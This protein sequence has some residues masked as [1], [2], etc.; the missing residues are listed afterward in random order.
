MTAVPTRNGRGQV[1]LLDCARAFLRF[2]SPKLIA[3]GL[4]IALAARVAVGGWSWLDLAVAASLV[5]FQPFSEWLIHVGLLHSKPRKLGPLTIDL[6]TAQL[7]RWHHRHPKNLQ[8]VLIPWYGIAAF[9]P[10]IA[11][12]MWLLTWPWVLAGG[13][14]SAL[15]LTATL[16]GYTL[17]ATYEWCHFII[18][19]PYRPKTRYYRSI[20]RTHRL[21]HFKN[22]HFWFGV[23]SDVGDRVLGTFPDQR[24]VPKSRTV[25]NLGVDSD[26][27][28]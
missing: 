4:A 6:P 26:V 2:P 8:T 23:S 13:D 7:H 9:L 18:H 19:T 28:A 16:C 15:F 14:H 22:E 10:M 27:G 21:H 1:N 5:A 24:V 17:L 25:R 12:T 3:T 20:W 11:G